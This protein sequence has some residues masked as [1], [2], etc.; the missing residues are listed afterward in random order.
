MDGGLGLFGLGMFLLSISLLYARSAFGLAW[1]VLALS[2]VSMGMAFAETPRRRDVA[3]VIGLVLIVAAAVSIAF[4]VAWWW[5]LATAL[6]GVAY[7][8]LWAEFRFAFFQ[9]VTQEA[10]G[11]SRERRRERAR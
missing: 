3:L 11:T 6:F 7:L 10:G 4:T 1:T 5:V 9:H 2:M 8:V